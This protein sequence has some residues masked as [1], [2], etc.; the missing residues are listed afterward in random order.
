MSKKDGKYLTTGEFAKLCKVNKQTIFYYD[1]IGI[2]SPVMKNEKGYRYYSIHQLELFFVID[3][4]KDLGMS[5]NDI[6]QY[7]Q[8]KS[9]ESFLSIM[10]RKKEEIVKKRQEIEMKEK[11]IEAKIAIMEEASHLDFNRITLQRLPEATLYLSRNIQNISDE[12]FLEVISDFINELQISQLDSGYPIGS[13]TKREQVLKGEYANYSYLYI[14]QPNPKEGHP[15]FRAV[16]GDF[17]IG[18]HVGSEKTIG[19]TYKRLFS[20]MER[21]GLTLGEHVFEEYIYDT[22]VRNDKEHYVTKIM[23]EVDRG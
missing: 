10:Y 19:D 20:E 8:N 17:L 9:P 21:L 16:K 3:L 18:Y 5:L 1:Q 15:Y 13:I 6:Q 2:L 12:E 4:L 22:V 23:M 14:E 11:M 7:M